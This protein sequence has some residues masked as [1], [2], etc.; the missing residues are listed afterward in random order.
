MIRRLLREE[1]RE[2]KKEIKEAV[3]VGKRRKELVGKRSLR[4]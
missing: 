2:I 4:S 1:L 3:V